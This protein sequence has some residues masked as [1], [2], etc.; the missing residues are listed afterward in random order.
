M[1][2]SASGIIEVGTLKTALHQIILFE[3]A[4]Q[5]WDFIGKVELLLRAERLTL[6]VRLW[7]YE[8]THGFF[9][10]AFTRGPTSVE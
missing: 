10:V 2:E 5:Q 8:L 3:G 4:L 6:E 7:P 9:H 1:V